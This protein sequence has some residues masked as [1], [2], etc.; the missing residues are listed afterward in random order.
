MKTGMRF[1]VQG[2]TAIELIIITAVVAVLVAFAS[3]LVSRFMS[4][5]ELRQAIEIT[6]SSVEHARLKARLYKTDVVMHLAE[7]QAEKAQSI[8]LSFP[9]M[10]KDP[11]LA[12]LNQE[13]ALPAG[14]QLV[15][16]APIIR[17][18]AEGKVGLPAHLYFI[19]NQSDRR[20]RPLVID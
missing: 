9:N 13:F 15:S 17:F 16:D 14:I 4:Q 18:N 19:A 11:A 7:Y 8:R 5:P 6:E 12:E 20:S 10:Q 1:A 3:P 2:I